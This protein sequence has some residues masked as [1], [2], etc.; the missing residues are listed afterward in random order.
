MNTLSINELLSNAKLNSLSFYKLQKL[1]DEITMKIE[2]LEED[3]YQNKYKNKYDILCHNKKRIEIIIK[4]KTRRL[5]KNNRKS[6]SKSPVLQSGIT[7]ALKTGIKKLIRTS[8]HG[9]AII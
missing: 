5:I 7:N 8:V 4:M 1:H 6:P 3:K 2:K 9:V